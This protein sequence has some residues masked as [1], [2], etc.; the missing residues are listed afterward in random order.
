MITVSTK[1]VIGGQNYVMLQ[2]SDSSDLRPTALKVYNLSAYWAKGQ[3][4][5]RIYVNRHRYFDVDNKGALLDFLL[6]WE[7]C[8]RCGSSS[9]ADLYVDEVWRLWHDGRWHLQRLNSQ[10][11]FW[12]E[13]RLNGTLIWVYN[14][15]GPKMSYLEWS[16]TLARVQFASRDSGMNA[17]FEVKFERVCR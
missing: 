16:G 6:A 9:S 1:L 2:S 17:V 11:G 14:A 13:V 8:L 15:R 4:T 7:D 3:S 10:G 5:A 12:H